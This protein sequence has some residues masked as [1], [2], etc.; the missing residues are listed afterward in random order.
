MAASRLPAARLLG[1]T[2]YRSEDPSG[3]YAHDCPT[4]AVDPRTVA[5]GQE[6]YV[7]I[8]ARGRSEAGR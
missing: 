5:P 8:R 7:T 4:E 3:I 2:P 1:Q 6:G